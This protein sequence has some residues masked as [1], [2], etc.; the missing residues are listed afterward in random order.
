M[1]LKIQIH[2]KKIKNPAP[3]YEM[4]RLCQL[5][6]FLIAICPRNQGIDRKKL[7]S[8]ISMNDHKLIKLKYT[9]FKSH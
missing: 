8:R 7:R 5:A 6:R 2:K 1:Q 4:F 9:N 3:N